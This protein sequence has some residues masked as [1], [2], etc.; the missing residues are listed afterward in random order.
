MSRPRSYRTEGVVIKST[1]MYEAG[2][3]VTLYSRSAGKL[4]AVVRGVR[5]PTSKMAGH[6]EPL[7]RV[8]L[9]LA[10]SS[11][12]DG[13]D[14]V[15][16]AQVVE[17]FASLKSDL[18]AVAKGIY[19]AELVD[20]F[21][22]EGSANPQLYDL[23]VDTLRALDVE[24]GLELALRRFELHLLKCSGFMPELH[25]CVSCR[26]ELVPDRHLF[27]PDLGGTLC[28][29]CT[30]AGAR[31]MRLSVAALKVMRFLD[32]ASLAD[33]PT[34]RVASDLQGELKNLFSVTLRYWLDREIRSR[35][36]MEHLEDAPRPEVYLSGA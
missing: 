17:S 7:T 15:T 30:P 35:K 18:E 29:E 26:E 4:R 5:K 16:Q 11:R 19:L 22:A 9:A 6:L 13:I 14:T 2:L 28:L 36:F 8:D 31:I 12:A 20:G 23:V 10:V 32:R 34:L 21:G 33:L 24:P 3:L 25:R 27:S 1:P